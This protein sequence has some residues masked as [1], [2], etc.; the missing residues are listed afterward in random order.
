MYVTKVNNYFTITPSLKKETVIEIILVSSGYVV[1]EGDFHLIR[2]NS[3]DIH[4]SISKR[5]QVIKE[6]S[7]DFEGW[8]VAFPLSS[9]YSIYTN[10]EIKSDIE[11]ISSFLY[12]YP[13]KLSFELYKRLSFHLNC[14]EVLSNKKNKDYILIYSYLQVC[15]LEVKN[16]MKENVLDFYPAKAFSITKKYNDLLL[17][18]IDKQT[19]IDFY[20]DLLNMTPNHLNKSV[21]SVTGK[22]AIQLL[23]EARL[24]E[25]KLKLKTTNLTVYDIADLLGFK[26]QSYFSRFFK[27]ATGITPI[28]FRKS[29]S[30]LS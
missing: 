30:N 28:D 20:A 12:K 29:S 6:I 21:K 2:I 14:L 22:T 7:Q 24:I 25:A 27:K 10:P 9:F 11:L 8:Y 17:T 3:K 16:F 1:I 13:L 5:T 19:H 4:I 18:Y 23:N 26:D 15:I